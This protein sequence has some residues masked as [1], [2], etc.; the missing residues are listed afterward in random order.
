MSRIFGTCPGNAGLLPKLGASAVLHEDRHKSDR[1]DLLG[2]QEIHR[3]SGVGK[4]RK[5]TVC[6][7]RELLGTLIANETTK[8]TL[9]S[10]AERA[11]LGGFRDFKLAADAISEAHRAKASA[12]EARRRLAEPARFVSGLPDSFRGRPR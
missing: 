5:C 3:H 12:A 7:G 1:G 9:A 11:F 6:D 2:L 8:S 4:R 10:N